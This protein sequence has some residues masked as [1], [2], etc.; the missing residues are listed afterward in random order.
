MTEQDYLDAV[1]SNT[2]YCI[3][4]KEFTR[5]CTEPDAEGYDC[6]ECGK[7]TVM[8]AEQALVC[9]LLTFSE[10]SEESEE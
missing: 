9:D 10:E 8:G 7:N 1:E 2:G 5:E 6:P 4:C 3:T